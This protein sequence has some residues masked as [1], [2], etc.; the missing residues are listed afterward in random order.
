VVCDLPPPRGGTDPTAAIR[1]AIDRLASA[2]AD[3]RAVI[4]LVSDGGFPMTVEAAV[5]AAAAAAARG[6]RVETFATGAVD[7]AGAARLCRVASAGGG[8]CHAAATA[9]AL[10]RA[11]P[12]PI[13]RSAPLRV[14]GQAAGLA[15]WWPSTWPSRPPP[16]RRSWWTPARSVARGPRPRR[17]SRRR[18]ASGSRRRLG[19]RQWPPR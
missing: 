9:L 11:A 19:R 8:A 15:T 6:V 12:A 14:R 4:A 13:A 16:T 17:R 18:W 10:L 5:A 3:A 1:R 2:P 7:A